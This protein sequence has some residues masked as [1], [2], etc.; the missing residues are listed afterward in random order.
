MFQ[1]KQ[2]MYI[3]P[4]TGYSVF[5]AHSHL[6]RGFCC[7]NACRHCPFGHFACPPGV[8]RNHVLKEPLLLRT[9]ASARRAKQ[10]V[11]QRPY[12]SSS[13]S[14]SASANLSARPPKSA[15]RIFN[16]SSSDSDSDESKC[17]TSSSTLSSSATT[18]ALVKMDVLFWTGGIDSYMSFLALKQ[19]GRK[20][21]LLLYFYYRSSNEMKF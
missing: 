13:S 9:A 20:G 3:D 4:Q 5:T 6:T 8:R 16:H 15:L 17:S 12:H 21:D 1:K 18:A 19:Q 7:G 2:S 10:R 11:V 14:S